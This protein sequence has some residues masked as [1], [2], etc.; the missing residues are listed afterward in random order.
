MTI[1]IFIEQVFVWQ[2]ITTQATVAQLKEHYTLVNRTIK[3][4]SMVVTLLKFKKENPKGLAI[5][6]TRTCKLAQVKKGFYI[7]NYLNRTS[8]YNYVFYLLLPFALLLY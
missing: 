3:D 8:L 4:A 1:K 7:F 5:I 6:F 2:S